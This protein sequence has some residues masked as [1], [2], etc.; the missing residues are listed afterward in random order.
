[1]PKTG[2]AILPLHYG[3]PPERLFRRMVKLGGILCDLISEKFGT[4]ALISKFADPFWFHSFALATGFDWN[5]SGTT[6]VL[7]SALKEY[8]ASHGDGLIIIGAK[9]DGFSTIRE[10]FSEAGKVAGSKFMEEAFIVSRDVAR[11]DN[12]LLQ[13]SFDLYLQYM[14]TDGNSWSIVQQGMNPE[15]RLARRYHWHSGISGALYDDARSGLSGSR[16][17]DGVLDLST[18]ASAGNRDGILAVIQDNPEKYA[19]SIGRGKQRTLEMG[20][21]EGKFL[22]LDVRINWKKLR[23]IYEYSPSGFQELYRM[24]GVGKSTVRALSY[25]SEIIY[26]E[27]PS[28]SDP[29]KFSFALG[30]KDGIPKPVDYADYDACISFFGEVLGKRGFDRSIDLLI[31]NLARSGFN[32]R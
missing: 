5:S 10:Q 22:N 12:N 30:G 20:N 28:F 21:A 18:K 16:I 7:L 11:V 26:G 15:V 24:K 19:G 31:D 14:V 17:M 23:D 32:L 2:T 9:G 29:L 4:E 25:L 1:M 8:Y 13:D 3:K 6:T 27:G